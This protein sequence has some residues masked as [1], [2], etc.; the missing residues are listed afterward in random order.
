MTSGSTPYYAQEHIEQLEDTLDSHVVE[1]RNLM[2]K[3]FQA[4]RKATDQNALT[5]FVRGAGRRLNIIQASLLE[6]FRVFPPNQVKRLPRDAIAIAQINHH[7]CLLNTFGLFD[8]WAWAFASE[9]KLLDALR[10]KHGVDLFGARMR[11]HLPA[12]IRGCVES[13]AI[14]KWHKNYLTVFRDEVA[15]RIPVYIPP[16]AW[17]KSDQE[18]FALLEKERDRLLLKM[19]WDAVDRVWAE[20]DQIG[21][22][23]PVVVHEETVGAK[24]M[25]FNLHAQMLADA[26]TVITIGKVFCEH[27][28]DSQ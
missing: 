8:N 25:S 6:V 10:G 4:A 1:L 3:N 5:F 27:W 7:A 24:S 28:K 9:F 14:A 21:V 16:A 19:D 26:N 11:E 12:P 18:R 23:C 13:E 17:T 20:I 2:F 22:A 15:H